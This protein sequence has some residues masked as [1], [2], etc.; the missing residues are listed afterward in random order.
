M[1]IDRASPVNR[2]V[3]DA[4]GLRQ[5]AAGLERLAKIQGLERT[6]AALRAENLALRVHV[7]ELE[8]LL[9]DTRE[10]GPALA[11]SADN[12]QPA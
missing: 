12:G 3:L 8:H 10:D 1:T 7:H 6:I 11:V 2:T 4:L 5:P 9:L